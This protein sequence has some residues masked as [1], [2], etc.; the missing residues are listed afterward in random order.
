MLSARVPPAKIVTPIIDQATETVVG[1]VLDGFEDH[2]W[3]DP[4][5]EPDAAR[6][7]V[8]Q[9]ATAI[10]TGVVGLVVATAHAGGGGAR[11]APPA[12]VPGENATSY[13]HRVERWSRGDPARR[14]V[15]ETA[16]VVH[17]AMVEGR[18][19]TGA[20]LPAATAWLESEV[21]DNVVEGRTATRR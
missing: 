13:V 7:A 9:E 8:E 1:A 4:P 21:S 6:A 10:T 18:A 5:A 11:P 20:V 12:P 3:T 16:A 14:E 17:D 15:F 2:G 19:A